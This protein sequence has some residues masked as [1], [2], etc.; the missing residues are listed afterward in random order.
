MPPRLKLS[1]PPGYHLEAV[2]GSYQLYFRYR[3]VVG[4]M[5]R[6]VYGFTADSTA[7]EIEAAAREHEKGSASDAERNSD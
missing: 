1:L 2:P 3:L 5:S 6:F 4:R 7:Q